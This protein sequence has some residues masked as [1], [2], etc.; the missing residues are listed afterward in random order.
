MAIEMGGVRLTVD[1]TTDPAY[2]QRVSSGVWEP[3]TIRALRCLI[4]PGTKAVDIGAWIGSISLMMSGLGA[5][6]SAFELD[7][8]ALDRLDLNLALNPELR[9]AIDV[10]RVGLAV[11]SGTADVSTNELGESR[12]SLV[13]RGSDHA[14]VPVVAVSA[15]AGAGWL[16]GDVVKLDIEGG[17]WLILRALSHHLRKTRPALLL[18]S[19]GYYLNETLPRVG[20]RLLR[21]V[22]FRWRLFSHVRAATSLR[23]YRHW[24]FADNGAWRRI[25]RVQ[26]AWRLMHGGNYEFLASMASVTGLIDPSTEW[27]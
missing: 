11:A 10:H 5:T 3:E 12:T 9:A 6:V 19:H 22:R 13:R 15:A 16:D 21:E 26:V 2:W 14:S 7:P 23:F 1:P 4:K 27:E 25:S 20:N 18:S 24:C 17:E 8:V